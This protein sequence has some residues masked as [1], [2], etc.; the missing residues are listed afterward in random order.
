MVKTVIINDL[1]IEDVEEI[2]ITAFGMAITKLVRDS[3]GN[4]KKTE[5]TMLNILD[6]TWIDFDSK[7]KDV[8]FIGCKNATIHNRVID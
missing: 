8:M 1:V 5:E 4:I 6:K 2:T 7:N 3:D